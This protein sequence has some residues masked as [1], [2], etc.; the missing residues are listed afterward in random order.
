MKKKYQKPRI[1]AK[2][3]QFNYFYSRSRSLDSMGLLNGSS[4]MLAYTCAGCCFVPGSKVLMANSEEKNI[5]EVKI[6]DKV[7]S[8]NLVAGELIKNK[9][10]RLIEK[11][12]DKGYL[13]INGTYKPTPNHPFWVNGK[14]WKRAD[15]IR[16]GDEL[17]N[18]ENKSIR[19]RSI[20]KVGG[21]YTVYNLH[22][23]NKEH[24][25]FVEKALV[26]N[27]PDSSF[28]PLCE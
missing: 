21:T 24:N 8:Y 11:S 16:V 6:N 25:F 27:S 13:I 19:V 20:K 22:L 14:A 10:V 4:V 18:N 2:K 26:H 1:T 12:Y 3:I 5:E 9:V 7:F 15:E 17:L 28:I 23:D